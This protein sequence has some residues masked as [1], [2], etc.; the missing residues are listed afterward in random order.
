M[1]LFSTE[2]L[3]RSVCAPEEKDS[4]C[5]TFAFLIPLLRAY[6][7]EEIDIQT[8]KDSIPQTQFPFL[9]DAIP[10]LIEAREW[11][12]VKKTEQYIL[13]ADPSQVVLRKMLEIQFFCCFRQ[14]DSMGL[15]RAYFEALLEGAEY[16]KNSHE[17]VKNMF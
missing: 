2:L 14:K 3:L 11:Q 8:F 1:S 6:R 15:L 10:A 12:I 9:Y 5:S 16:S 7:K 4:L 13:D 17:R